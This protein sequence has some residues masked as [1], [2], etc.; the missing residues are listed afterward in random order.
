LIGK[1]LL[2]EEA[3]ELIILS[4]KHLII[5]CG[6]FFLLCLDIS[7]EQSPFSSSSS[8]VS[9]ESAPPPLK[10]SPRIVL[11]ALASSRSSSSSSSRSELLLNSEPSIESIDER[12][13]AASSSRRT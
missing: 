12:P 13:E 6:C 9:N 2:K 8:S 5:N 4:F 11:V 10:R 1:K 3:R 7:D